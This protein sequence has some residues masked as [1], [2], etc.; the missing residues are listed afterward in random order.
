MKLQVLVSTM[1]QENHS[2]LRKMNISSDVLVVNQCNRVEIEEF[3]YDENSVMWISLQ[4]RGIGLSRNTALMRA[5]AD[6]CLFADDDVEYVNGYKDIIC[7]T[8][9]DNPEADVIMFNV[10]STNVSRPTYIIKKSSRVR[11]YNS[12]RYGAVKIAVKTERI[13]Q[14]NIY[15]SLLFGGGAKY[16]AGEDSLFVADCIKNGLK[17]YAN[18]EIIGY[19]KQD[20]SSWFEG[21]T[22]KYFYDKGVFY[23]C[24]S[25]KWARLLALQDILRHNKKWRNQI[26]IRRAYKLILKGIKEVK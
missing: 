1:Y 22:D 8:F 24:L 4:E 21:Y 17:V 2:L 16:S 19:V 14:K 20:E 11:W 7:K 10:P 26:K 18:P 3:K 15:F 13:R 12:L 5:T 25:K 23:A 6:I 9:E